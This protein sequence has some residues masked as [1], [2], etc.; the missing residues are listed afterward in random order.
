MDWID[1]TRSCRST[2]TLCMAGWLGDRWLRSAWM[3]RVGLIASV[4][5]VRKP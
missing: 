2:G 1:V 4:F 5:L 3:S